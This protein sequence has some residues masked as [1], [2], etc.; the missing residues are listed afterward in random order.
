MRVKSLLTKFFIEI[1]L[2]ST[3][4]TSHGKFFILN[5]QETIQSNLL[6]HGQFE[7]CL[8]NIA[9]GLAKNKE[10]AIVDVGANIGTFTIALAKTFLDRK[11]FSFEPQQQ[12]MNH[13]C[14]NIILNKLTNVITFKCAV[15]AITEGTSMQVPIFD[16]FDEQYTGS[17]SLDSEVQSLRRNISGIAEPS[18]FAEEFDSVPV[19]QLDDILEGQIALIKIDVEGMELSVLKS[20]IETVARDQPVILFEAWNLVE[21]NDKNQA[22][23]DFVLDLGYKIHRL[24]DDCV[25]FHKDDIETEHY[26]L[27]NCTRNTRA[28]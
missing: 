7:L 22:V 20:C 14:A 10:G 1:G 4:Q 9:A 28:I 21:F 6:K 5:T 25:A 26:L 13:L 12:V 8:V 18:L 15:A 19:V 16:V 17:V 24:E 11:V 27:N 23:F 3:V 2:K